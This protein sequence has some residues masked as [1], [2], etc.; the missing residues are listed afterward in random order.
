MGTG[1]LYAA[2]V[3]A[4]AA[5]LLPVVKHRREK[6]ADGRSVAPV[7]TAM[8][9]LGKRTSGARPRTRSA[10][11]ASAGIDTPMTDGSTTSEPS[12]RSLADDRRRGALA[13]ARRRRVLALILGTAVV[14][15]VFAFV[16]TVPW[17]SVAI[18]G[19]MF[20]AFLVVARLTVRAA[21]RRRAAFRLRSRSADMSLD[22]SATADPT[23]AIVAATPMLAITASAAAPSVEPTAAAGPETDTTPDASDPAIA[24]AAA[25]VA[26]SP[27]DAWDPLPIT[28][29]TYVTKAAAPTR[30]VRTIDL[31]GASAFSAGRL[32]EAALLSRQDDSIEDVGA[33]DARA[34]DEGP[35]RATG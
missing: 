33:A 1:I 11:E 16:G 8:R 30:R 5:Y 20:V 9:V 2:I 15:A 3:V 31:S 17:W 18:P 28:L 14:V 24:A 12:E 26:H 34:R 25:W 35:S 23:T 29:P 21:R 22:E 4:W 10:T 6:A 7:S 13:A 32:P 19:A 27:V